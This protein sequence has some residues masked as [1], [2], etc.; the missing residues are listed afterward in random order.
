MKP[1]EVLQEALTELKKGPQTW[2]QE[3]YA[4]DAAG[5]VVDPTSPDAVCRCAIGHV[6]A[7]VGPHEDA[8]RYLTKVVE[9]LPRLP[10]RY[11]HAAIAGKNDSDETKYEDVVAIFEKAVVMAKKVGR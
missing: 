5:G 6:M 3:E 10:K 7:V 1:S 4:K 8:L 2:T 9:D 11:S